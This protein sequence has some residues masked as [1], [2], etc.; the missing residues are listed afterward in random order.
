LGGAKR[1]LKKEYGQGFGLPGTGGTDLGEG[2]QKRGGIGNKKVKRPQQKPTKQAVQKKRD[3]RLK[4]APRTK[5]RNGSW[6]ARF[7]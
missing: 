7:W 5:Q 1:G 2:M 3:K 4:S 6:M